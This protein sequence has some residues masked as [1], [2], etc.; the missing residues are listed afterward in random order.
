MFVHFNSKVVNSDSI[1]WIDHR[2]L[3]EHGYVN[4]YSKDGQRELVEGPE[5]FNLI[6]E[7]AP[8][9]LEGK[10]A[11][12]QR[13]AWAVHNLIGHPLMQIFSWLHLPAVGIKIHDLTVPNPIT[14]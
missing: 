10:Q 1:D 4:V 6:M 5:A 11:K 14:K 3:V 8:A 7:L 9:A 12:Y 2:N 13:H